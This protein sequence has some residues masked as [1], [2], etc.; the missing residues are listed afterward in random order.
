MP[1][2]IR[3]TSLND[4]T[5]S[6]LARRII[7]D[8]GND[9]DVGNYQVVAGDSVLQQEIGL[10]LPLILGT[11]STAQITLSARGTNIGLESFAGVTLQPIVVGAPSIESADRLDFAL[12]DQ[13]AIFSSIT[14]TSLAFIQALRVNITA[15]N[16]NIGTVTA[17]GSLLPVVLRTHGDATIELS[18]TGGNAYLSSFAPVLLVPLRASVSSVL[19]SR[20]STVISNGLAVQTVTP[21]DF[22]ITTNSNIMRALSIRQLQQDRW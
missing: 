22:N 18:L 8:A 14:A 10:R 3:A 21:G 12:N 15:E 19:L 9:S 7:L 1:F 4:T 20:T 5:D 2:G 13:G 6:I 16:G 11:G 17:S